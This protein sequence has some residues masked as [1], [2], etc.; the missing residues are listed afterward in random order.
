MTLF[1]FY[2]DQRTGGNRSLGRV[3]KDLAEPLLVRSDQQ[4]AIVWSQ[5]VGSKFTH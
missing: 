2:Y 3:L 4:Q 5:V 1:S